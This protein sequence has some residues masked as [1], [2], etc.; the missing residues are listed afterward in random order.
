VS[1]K[2]IQLFIKHVS[3]VENSID[4]ADLKYVEKINL[5]F[6]VDEMIAKTY[7]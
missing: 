2:F 6:T 1:I 7:L 4:S 5:P 3:A